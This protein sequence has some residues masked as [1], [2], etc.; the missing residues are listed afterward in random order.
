MKQRRTA[1]RMRAFGRFLEA[2]ATIKGLVERVRALY[3]TVDGTLFFPIRTL[4][5]SSSLLSSVMLGVICCCLKRCP[6]HLGIQSAQCGDKRY[7]GVTLPLRAYA[8]PV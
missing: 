6:H 2:I 1:S 7:G 8:R 4:S 3:W 5:Y